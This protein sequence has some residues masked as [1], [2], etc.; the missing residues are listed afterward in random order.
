LDSRRNVSVE[1]SDAEVREQPEITTVLA[2]V[3]RR[4]EKDLTQRAQR[5]EHRERGES[6]ADSA[7][8]CIQGFGSAPST[9]VELLAG[10]GAALLESVD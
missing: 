8:Q 5:P 2:N 10:D 4:K 3:R 9:I 7:V 1:G 6:L